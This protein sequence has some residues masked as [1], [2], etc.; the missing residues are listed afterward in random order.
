MS[1]IRNKTVDYDDDYYDDEYGSYESDGQSLSNSMKARYMKDYKPSNDSHYEETE[2][3]IA[4]M[5]EDVAFVQE[6]TENYF[7]EDR[8][9]EEINN[10]HFDRNAALDHLLNIKEME[11][12]KK[13]SQELQKSFKK[14]QSSRKQQNIVVLN[15]SGD[16]ITTPNKDSGKFGQ[17]GRNEKT[18]QP[19]SFGRGKKIKKNSNSFQMEEDSFKEESKPPLDLKKIEIFKTPVSSLHDSEFGQCLTESENQNSQFILNF[20]NKNPVKL[21][22]PL[23]VSVFDFEGESPD[24]IILKTQKNQKLT[25]ELE[26]TPVVKKKKEKKEKEESPVLKSPTVDPFSDKKK[27]PPPEDKD[28]KRINVVIIG[29]VDAGKSTLMGHVL[30]ASGVV[31]QR[32]IHKFEKESQQKGKS[33]FHFAWVMDQQDEER[34]RGITMDIGVKYFE[35]KNKSVTILD[36]PGHADFISKM[37][38]GTTQADFA[39]LVVDSIKGAFEAGFQ[40]GGQTKEHLILSRSLGISKYIVAVNKL[41][42]C[43]WSIERFNEIQTLLSEFMKANGINLSNVQF[44]PLSGLT[45]EN[46]SKKSEQ[47]NWYEGKCLIDIIDS[48]QPSK[49]SV[50]KGL[51]MCI[52]DVYKTMQSGITIAGKVETGSISVHDKIIL[53]PEQV[54]AV[55]KSI[56]RNKNIV[57][58]AYAGDNL[59]IGLDKVDIM[60]L[61]V[62]QIVCDV[63]DKIP[64]TDKFRAHIFTFDLDIPI[65]PGTDCVLHYQNLNVPVTV[66]KLY[67]T[68]DKNLQVKKKKPRALVKG[69]TAEIQLKTDK[70]IYLC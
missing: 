56:S 38:T 53:M 58:V 9:V 2:D 67:S 29:H 6:Y 63:Y 12:K 30:Y 10:H 52:S 34:N 42:K 1:K 19:L 68:L 18:K 26:N 22:L 54:T 20:L 43:E 66:T 15:N 59:E 28:K 45:G 47:I 8:V 48:I 65:L 49:R 41:D 51:R 32:D 70:P 24:D 4:Q 39:I 21:T 3:E 27:K 7:S 37:I 50:D 36:A 46:L 16:T 23:D 5:K 55:V 13:R 60:T 57:K 25:K 33:S 17:F 40:D 61:G 44:V 69:E 35:T 14:S 11:E 31:S 62:G 64:V